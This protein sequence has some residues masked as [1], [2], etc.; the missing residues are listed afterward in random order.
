MKFTLMQNG[1]IL[2]QLNEE[3]VLR[4]DGKEEANPGP[5]ALCRCGHS[6][7]KPFCDGSHQSADFK[8]PRGELE[9]QGPST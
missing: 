6:G 7:N 3:F 2:V 1:P 5:I 8:A 4:S 9:T